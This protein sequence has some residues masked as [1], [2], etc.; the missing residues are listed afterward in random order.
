MNDGRCCLEFDRTLELLGRFLP[1]P[2]PSA[3][4]GRG[5]RDLRF[6]AVQTGLDVVMTDPV[7]IPVE[8]ARELIEEKRLS[9][10]MTADL[11]LPARR[12]SRPR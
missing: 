12:G 6:Q 5:H 1:P 10:S 11:G 2:G 4:C 8:R 9:D 7:Q 3:G